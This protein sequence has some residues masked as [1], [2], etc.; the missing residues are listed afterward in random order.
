LRL[1][2]G[3]NLEYGDVLFLEGRLDSLLD[4]A[5]PPTHSYLAR[6]GIYSRMQYPQVTTLKRAAGSPIMAA[7]F[8]L[9]TRAQ[10]AIY[11]Q[12]PFPE[13]ALLSAILLGTDWNLPD[14]LVEAYRACG[15]LHII[16]ISGFNIA[17]ISNLIIRLAR[18]VIRPRQ[19]RPVRDHLH[20]VVYTAGW[21]RTGCGARRHHGQ[22]GHPGALFRSAGHSAA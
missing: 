22:P 15:V 5:S 20:P 7:L 21:R 2:G 1:P 12:I 18:R 9:R 3:F 16:A 17:I 19:S 4:S 10:Q 6:R 14:Y 11:R 8:S 13:S